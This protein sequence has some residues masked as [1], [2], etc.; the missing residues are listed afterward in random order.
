[1]AEDDSV[2]LNCQQCDAVI[3]FSEVSKVTED[4]ARDCERKYTGKSRDA[5]MLFPSF[6]C[7]KWYR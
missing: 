1:M 7:R 5:G 6:V 4:Y 3:T 2:T